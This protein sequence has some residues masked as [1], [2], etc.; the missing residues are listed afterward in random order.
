[1]EH[2]GPDFWQRKEV[3]LTKEFDT[4]DKEK[5]T[6]RHEEV[7][8]TFPCQNKEIDAVKKQFSVL[9]EKLSVLEQIDSFTDAQISAEA[10]KAIKDSIA[11]LERKIDNKITDDDNF[12]KFQ[13]FQNSCTEQR[14]RSWTVRISNYWSPHCREKITMFNR[15]AGFLTSYGGALL[16]KLL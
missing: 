12:K 8:N 10:V 14:S 7:F 3:I 2:L 13:F 15:V 11:F 1:M 5:A 9:S 6:V 4:Y 16:K